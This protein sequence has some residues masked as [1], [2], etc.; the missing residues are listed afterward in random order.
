[1]ARIAL[2]TRD[3]RRELARREKGAGKLQKRHAKLSKQLAVVEREMAD[4]GADAPAR[5]GRKPGRMGRRGPGRPKGSAGRGRRAKGGLTLVQALEHGVRAGTTVS[6][7]E[8]A[9]AAKR[10]GYKTKSKTFGVQVATALAKA[11]TFK[12]LGR[13]QYQ[14]LGT[15]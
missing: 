3:L 4:L 9:A 7:A 10:A 13:G 1:M 14:R 6:P 11:K 8:A 12:K 5:R 15:P 2:S